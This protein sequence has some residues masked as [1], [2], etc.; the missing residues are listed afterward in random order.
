[1][2]EYLLKARSLEKSFGHVRVLR[3]VDFDVKRNEVTALVGDNGAGKSTTVKILSGSLRAD[4]GS[5]ELD[6]HEVDFTNP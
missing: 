3:G 6:G 1:M 2:T 4:S 5:I